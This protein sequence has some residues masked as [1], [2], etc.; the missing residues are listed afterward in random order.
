[1]GRVVVSYTPPPADFT[2]PGLT[3]IAHLWLEFLK[4]LQTIH[5]EQVP[6]RWAGT[7]SPA[8]LY[9]GNITYVTARGWKIV[10]FLDC[11]SWDYLDDA[12]T[13][14]GISVRDE[15][16]AAEYLDGVF[17]TVYNPDEAEQ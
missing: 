17:G 10:V 3:R 8:E 12:I 2:T 1:M 6:L 11:P 14:D 13:P 4:E 15:M 5:A 16:G 7:E 9:T